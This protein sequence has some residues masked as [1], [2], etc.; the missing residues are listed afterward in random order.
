MPF[1]S[2]SRGG[3]LCHDGYWS[4]KAPRSQVATRAERRTCPG[5]SANSLPLKCARPRVRQITSARSADEAG[6][7]I[8][9]RTDKRSLSKTLRLCASAVKMPSAIRKTVSLTLTLQ[10]SYTCSELR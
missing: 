1:Q 6:E 7:D 10:P 4:G 2:P 8:T 5:A 3:Y 9:S